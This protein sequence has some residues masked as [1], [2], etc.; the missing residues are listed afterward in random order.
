MAPES[1]AP[2]DDDFLLVPHSNLAE[3]RL[4]SDAVPGTACITACITEIV[5][6]TVLTFDVFSSMRATTVRQSQVHH[7][8]GLISRQGCS[9]GS[10]QVC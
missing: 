5:V 1:A 2:C 3:V 10:L 8:N 7:I 9:R 6:C 4:L